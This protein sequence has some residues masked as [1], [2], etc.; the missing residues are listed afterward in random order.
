M[1]LAIKMSEELVEFGVPGLHFYT[2]NLETSVLRIIEGMQLFDDWKAQRELPWK[3]TLNQDK[4]RSTNEMVRPI[5]WA[6]RPTSYIK[7][8]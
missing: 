5:F 3:P 8:T 4:D 1:K 6:N 2:L 7:R